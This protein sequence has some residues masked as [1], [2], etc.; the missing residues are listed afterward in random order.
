[1]SKA[2][3]DVE[4]VIVLPLVKAY[5]NLSR[6]YGEVSCIAGVS[7]E[8]SVAL[9]W[10]R[11]YPV[12]FRDLADGRKFH[13][14]QP[15]RARARRPKGDLRP[16]SRRVDIDSIEVIGDPI[17]P[18]G[19]WRKRRKLIEPMIGGSMCEL[20]K[21]EAAD[22]TSLGMFHPADVT[23]LIIEAVEPDPEKG[24]KAEAWA[25]Q[26]R[27]GESSERRDERKALEQIPY[28]FKYRYRCSSPTCSGHNQ[29]IVDWEVFQLYR[30]VRNRDNWE[31][32]MRRKWL[33]EM[34]SPEK[35]TAF[36]VGNQHQYRQGFLVLGVWWPP[37]DNQLSLADAIDL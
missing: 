37:L 9:S 18:T 19:G 30:Q 5:P 36:I 14:Y 6:Q 25:A 23:D 26:G 27:L 4:S 10:I 12:P 21:A 28:R 34:C 2:I 1:M 33:D 3:P 15:I 13:K 17:D 35:D 31:E 24:E 7:L 29:S 32:L 8:N 22:R 20:M 16:E 11:I